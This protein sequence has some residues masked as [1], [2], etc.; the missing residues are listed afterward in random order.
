MQSDDIQAYYNQGREQARLSADAG[1]LER[2]RTQEIILRYLSPPPGTLLD[3]GGGAGIYALW[4]AQ[5]GYAVH[6]VDMV[7]LHVE[8][9]Q[10]A[11]ASQPQHPLASAVLGNALQ[12]EFPDSFA[13]AVLLLGP[14]YHLTER[15]QRISALSEAYRVLKPSGYLFAACISRF[16]SLLDGMMRGYLADAGFAELTERDLVDGQH[17]NPTR[18]RGYFTT[19][20]FH[21]PS[22]IQAEVSEAG[23][24]VEAVLPVEGPA[25]FMPNIDG[26]WQDAVLRERLLS[27]LRLTENEP[28]MLGATGHIL[29]V[30]RKD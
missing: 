29:A 23:F 5:R 15:D 14:L 11:S 4:L 8:Q 21:H 7:P 25:G 17:R 13:N 22:E 26:F 9:A 24:N 27:L 1:H 18:Q 10:H 20:Y 12:L 19:A 30:G 3:I 2:T 28:S 16:A 6:L